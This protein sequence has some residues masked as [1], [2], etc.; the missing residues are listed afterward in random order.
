M[1]AS[2]CGRFGNMQFNLKHLGFE[3][4]FHS[5]LTVNPCLGLIVAIGRVSSMSDQAPTLGLHTN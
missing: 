3:N 5:Q 2:E 4:Q 1:E